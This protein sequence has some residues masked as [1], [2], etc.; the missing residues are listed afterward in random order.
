MIKTEN[1]RLLLNIG[2]NKHKIMVFL[3]G[4]DGK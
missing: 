2:F 1:K 3:G 4:S